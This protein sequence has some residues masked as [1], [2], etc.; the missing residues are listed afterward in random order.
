VRPDNAAPTVQYRWHDEVIRNA[1]P[2]KTAIAIAKRA[3]GSRPIEFRFLREEGADET[4]YSVDLSS[5]R[6]ALRWNGSTGNKLIVRGQVDRTGAFPR[7]ST[8]V[9]GQ[10]L[11][12]TIC[13]LGPI[14]FCYPTPDR[15]AAGNAG[16][17]QDLADE[18]AT[19]M[20]N[21]NAASRGPSEIRFRLHCFLL[22]ESQNVEFAEM[23]FRDCW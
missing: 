14:D 10:P 3:N 21:R 18:V 8:I 12:K 17:H 19:E 20:E 4:F 16:R 2:V 15:A 11:S 7:A 13:K 9:V 22:W 23:G 5:Y 1:I 6:S